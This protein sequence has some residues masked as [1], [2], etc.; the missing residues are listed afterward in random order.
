MKK[1]LC[2]RTLTMLL[3]FS[4]LAAF[5]LSACG[6]DDDG[7]GAVIDDIDYEW[8]DPT[9]ADTSDL[10]SWEDLGQTRTLSLTAWNMWDGVKQEAENDVVYP[11]IRRVT[12]VTVDTKNSFD[13]GG[14]SFTERLAR[15]RQLDGYRTVLR[16]YRTRPQILPDDYEAHA[17]LHLE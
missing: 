2:K 12:G 1:N 6:K 7:P 16:P 8:L 15:L 3:A 10:T 14:M 13:N 5:G 9:I 17:G 4:T 11:E